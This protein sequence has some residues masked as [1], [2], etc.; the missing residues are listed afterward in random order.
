M[1]V[2][3]I[4]KEKGDGVSFLE[5]EKEKKNL[6]D[7]PQRH[8]PSFLPPPHPPSLVNVEKMK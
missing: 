1:L 8:C 6:L 2:V 7:H 3:K 5:E 4:M